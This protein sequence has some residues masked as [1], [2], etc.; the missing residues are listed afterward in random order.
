MKATPFHPVSSRL[1]AIII[2]D[3]VGF[4][5]LV[6]RNESGNIDRI[7]RS[8]KLFR[9]LIEDYGGEVI[10]IA[11]DGIFALFD[12]AARAI[13]FAAE[14]QRELKNEVVWNEDDEP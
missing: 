5:R 13:R 8:I 6:D 1:S 11:G 2:A 7:S 3:I 12:S 9:D 4:S 10:N 14:F